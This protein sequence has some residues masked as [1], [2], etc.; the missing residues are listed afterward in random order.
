MHPG[1]HDATAAY[2]YHL[3]REW[4][5]ETL[6][7]PRLPALLAELGVHLIS[8]HQLGRAVEQLAATRG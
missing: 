3:D 1:Y 8:Y 6:S 4:E 2:V 5:L 7:D